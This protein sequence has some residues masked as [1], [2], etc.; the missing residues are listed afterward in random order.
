[1]SNHPWDCE[2]RTVLKLPC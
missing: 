2:Q 1:M